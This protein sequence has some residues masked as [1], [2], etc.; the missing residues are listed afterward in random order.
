MNRQFGSAIKNLLGSPEKPKSP[1][2]MQELGE[3]PDL[4]EMENLL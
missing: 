3:M 1:L 2:K 4:D